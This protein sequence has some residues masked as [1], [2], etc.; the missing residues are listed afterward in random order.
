MPSSSPPLSSFS[1]VARDL[2]ARSRRVHRARRRRR[3]RRAAHAS[4]CGRS[5]RRRQDDAAAP[6]RRPSTVPIAARSCRPRRRCGSATCRRS[7]SGATRRCSRSWPAA[8]A[9]PPP[10]PSSNAR[11]RRSPASVDGD[12]ADA[13]SAALDAYLAAGGPDLD[14]R[15][16][17]VCA[18]LGLPS[19][20]ARPPD[21]RTLRRA[22]GAGVAG[23]HPAEP[24]RRVPARRTDQRPR[25]RRAR[26]ARV[27]PRRA[28]WWRGGR[29]PR[30]RLSRTHREPCARARRAHPVGNRVRRWM[31]RLPRRPRDG[32]PA[33]DG[34]LRVVPRR[35]VP[36]SSSGRARNASGRCRA[37]RKARRDPSEKDKFIR[38]FKVAT[39][40]KQAAKARATEQAIARLDAV[41][42]PWEGLGSP[43]PA[44]RRRPAAATSSCGCAAR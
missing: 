1:L 19:S 27:V 12:A 16:R 35:D 18:D 24:V 28:P 6:A 32:T 5:E 20:R 29:Q 11:R 38:H 37:S 7:P 40:E 22:G 10:K 42:K 36:A 3:L 21:A 17:S 4:R 13:Y 33:R 43:V 30:P 23:G 8:P 2:V 26:T 34:G 9:W 15:A 44:R 31:A 14:A 25:L 41:E 39:S